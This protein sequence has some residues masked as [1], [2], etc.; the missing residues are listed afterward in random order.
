MKMP[1]KIH[2]KVLILSSDNVCS[3]KISCLIQEDA[4]YDYHIEI[5]D[6]LNSRTMSAD[7]II[8][9]VLDV[10]F[11]EILATK[12]ETAEVVLCASQDALTE[13]PVSELQ[14]FSEILI[15]P[16]SDTLLKPRLLHVIERVVENKKN[17]LQLTWFN[18]LIN[19]IPEMIWFKDKKGEHLKVNDHFC[20]IVG[21][22]KSD[23]EGRGHYYIWDITPEDYSQGEF[24]CLESEDVV[25]QAKET[26][27]FDESV[28]VKD[29]MLRLKTYKAP[30]F[31]EDGDIVGTLGYA[32]DV[33]ELSKQT[34]V[35]EDLID[36]LPFP[37]LL[38]DQENNI[39]KSNACFN[40]VFGGVDGMDLIRG[41][42]MEDW[43]DD[44]WDILDY[45]DNLSNMTASIEIEGKERE[46]SLL[47]NDLASNFKDYSGSLLVCIETNYGQDEE[48]E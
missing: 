31:G 9:D 36:G 17:H 22:E 40:T 43:L 29:G 45:T 6:Q 30:I 44:Y 11:L 35:V 10:S 8:V 2:I 15:K 20:K 14:Q 27:V 34:F 38:L 3:K 42:S 25:M 7:I 21:K 19:N 47:L 48:M 41:E 46:F 39:K 16:C 32:Q 13:I 26:R 12:K 18:T 24:I 37:I 23:I 4:E 1:N 33:T 28:K 5:F